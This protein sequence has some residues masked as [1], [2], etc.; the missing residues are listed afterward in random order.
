MDTKL[1]ILI[2]LSSKIAERVSIEKNK[3]YI[4]RW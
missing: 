2:N 1:N 4:L 3:V